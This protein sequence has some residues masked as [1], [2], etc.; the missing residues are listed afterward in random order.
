M[1][2]RLGGPV[3]EPEDGWF[4]ASRALWNAGA[5]GLLAVLILVLYTRSRAI[6]IERGGG[7]RPS[8]A[9]AATLPTLQ[10]TL[11][12]AAVVFGGI[13]MIGLL[14][15]AFISFKQ[16]IPEFQAYGPMDI[17]LTRLD[18]LLHVGVDP[19]RLLHPLLGHP[20]VTIGIDFIYFRWYEVT[21]LGFA[22][23]TF[24]MRGSRRGQFLLAFSASWV[25]LGFVFATGMASVGPCFTDRLFGG[26]STF[27]PLMAYLGSVNEIHAL[28]ALDL[29]EQLWQAYLTEPLG[30]VSGI[31][32][33]P[34]LHVAIPALF[35]V[36]VWHRSRALSLSV[37]AYTAVIVVGSVHLGWH[38]ALDGY[39]S[40]ALVFPIWWA[41]GVAARWW[42]AR[43]RAWRWRWSPARSIREDVPA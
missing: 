41:S 29:Q 27:T 22:A 42:Y 26:E 30:W 1:S 33:M 38:Y 4:D 37:W 21:L 24:W 15:P 17:A 39:A 3:I 43:T 5:W 14:M 9:F 20:W 25:I 16:A 18:Q 31:S 13:F 40:I 19:W 6:W 2:P 7:T 35:A 32:A 8:P 11:P 36:S 34:S 12:R 28:H 10:R 23:L